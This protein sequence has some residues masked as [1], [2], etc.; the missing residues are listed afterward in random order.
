[1]K[2]F[3]AYL[4]I[5]LIPLIYS[6]TYYNISLVDCL[7]VFVGLLVW[8]AAEYGFHRFAFHNRQLGVSAH[9]L[10]AYNH[11]Q[12]HTYP[13]DNGDLA[14]P[15]RLTLPV[16]VLLFFVAVALVSV[17]A[18]ALFFAGMF[19]G[20]SFYEFV[21]YQAHHKTYNIWPFNYLTQ[22]HMKHHYETE[23]KIYGVTSPLFDWIF[24]TS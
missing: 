23:N 16:A 19:I 8:E 15:L 9:K 21:H 24:R 4:I 6:F 2:K 18:A 12:H 11:L 10:L 22:R 5:V 20:L 17:P 7:A 14:L 1:M 13:D 3:T